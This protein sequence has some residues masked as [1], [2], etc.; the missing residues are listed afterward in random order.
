MQTNANQTRIPVSGFFL[1]LVTAL[2]GPLAQAGPTLEVWAADQADTIPGIGGGLIYIWDVTDLSRNAAKAIPEIIDLADAA[3][4]AESV[5]GTAGCDPVGRRPHMLQA[6]ASNSHMTVSHTATE[7]LYFINT[8]TR[9]IT[10]CVPQDAHFASGSPD[11]SM[12]I[13]GD[14]GHKELVRVQTDYANETYS[15]TGELSTADFEVALGTTR[16]GPVCGEFTADGRFY[17]TTI[18]GGGLLVVAVGSADGTIPMTVAKVYPATTVPGIGCGALRLGDNKMLTT[19]E[20]GAG[21]GDDFLYVFDTSG[22]T[23]GSFPDP[24]QI[25]LPGEDVH[26]LVICEQGNSG[27]QIAVASMRVSNEINAVDL[28]NNKVKTT[29]SMAR[30]FSPDP[31]PDVADN[32]GREMFIALRGTQPVTAIGSL[33]NAARTPGVAVLHLNSSC[34]NFEFNEQDIAPMTANPN[35]V[36]VDGVEVSA[37][38]PHGLEVIVR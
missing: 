17:Y 27:R 34:K 8:A 16:S 29:R 14:I 26:G 4:E 18:Q 5:L 37:A 1:V 9:A 31:K 3:E 33:P 25:D 12:V 10:G 21:G 20:S 19:G 24:I 38:D 6:N 23:G 11:E 36:F 13:A 32:V 28:T 22:N 7:S 15:I 35:T 30:S 2:L